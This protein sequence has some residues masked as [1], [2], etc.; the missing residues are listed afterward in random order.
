[1]KTYQVPENK[2]LRIAISG[3]SGC[4]NTTVSK[5][6]SEMLG[7]RMINYTF[8]NLAEEQNIPLSTII[9]NAKTDDSYDR[10]VDTKQVE[11][12]R[13]VSCVLGSRLAVWMLPE[14]DLKVYLFASPRVRA[15][16]IQNREGGTLEE[17]MNFTSMRDDA[18]TQRYKRLYN[19]DNRKYDFVDLIIDTEKMNPDQIT[20]LIIETLIKKGLLVQG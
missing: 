5:K 1:M 18:D 13:E 8:R 19:I 4:G 7:V 6:L 12:A 10:T 11:M 14:A 17:I 20:S 9:E 16:R 3:L 15:E 2:K